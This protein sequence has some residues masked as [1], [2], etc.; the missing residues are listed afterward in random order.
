MNERDRARLCAILLPA[1]DGAPFTEADRAEVRR[2]LGP[3]TFSWPY[4]PGLHI[5]AVPREH[6]PPAQQS[7]RCGEPATHNCSSERL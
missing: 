6:H 5:P 4:D 3:V 1:L 7:T 2:L